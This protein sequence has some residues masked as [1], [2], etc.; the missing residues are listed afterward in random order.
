[1]EPVIDTHHRRL[2][3]RERIATCIFPASQEAAAD[4][5]RRIVDLVER[6]NSENKHAVLG[7]ATGHTPIGVY[8]EL[9]AHHQRGVDFSKVIT[10]NLDEYYPMSPDG[11]QSYRRWMLENFF[12]H[13]NLEHKNIHVPDG[14]IERDAVDDYC[15]QYE[16]MIVDAGGIDIQLLG[17]GRTGHIGFNEPGSSTESITRLIALDTVTRRDAAA[18][19]FGEESVPREAITMGV[20]TILQ[21]REVILMAFGEQKA[22]IIKQA[23]E[24]PVTGSVP[25]TYLHGHPNALVVVDEAAAA[26]LTRR[27]SPWLLGEV[28][29]DDAKVKKAV[30]WLSETTGKSLLK[31]N[32]EDYDL[33]SLATALRRYPSVDRLNR[34]VFR[35]LADTI[36]GRIELPTDKRML[37]LSPHPDDDVISMGGAIKKLI[38]NGNQVHVS[39]QTSGNIAVFDEDA[40][41]VA[42]LIGYLNESF[43][44]AADK[45]R[46]FVHNVRCALND[47]SAGQPDTSEV[48]TIKGLI[49][50]SE[51]TAACRH[52]GVADERIH[53]LDLPFYQ[54]GLVR[55]LPISQAD[56]DI[57]RENILEVS[58]EWIFL[59]G[60]MSDPHGTHRMCADAIFGALKEIP[61][62]KRPE[63]VWLYRG[64]WQEWEPEDI[65]MAIPLTHDELSDKVFGIFKHESQKDKALF[66]GPYD[67]REFWQRAEARNRESA[68]RFD[69]MGLPEYYAM[70]AFVRWKEELG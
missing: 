7:L 63:Q 41:Q 38:E 16:R 43:G 10:F 69:R 70:E 19:F 58:P 40:V 1:M 15:A 65:D 14:A 68:D 67:H 31:L 13:I 18:D 27:K 28:E 57:V 42:E 48:Q 66:P 22:P 29:W 11:L 47:K 36:C 39:Y 3:S 12:D 25:A 17:I 35:A 61:A 5:A 46:D 30:I 55:K 44:F 21:A 49:R 54:T 26:D 56:V 60:E 37:V 2:T 33:H 62:S 64:A 32:R 23:V 34:V 51:A 50:R 59:A 24:G 52:M 4:V 20:G 6:R 9:I 8:Q 45:T 53:F